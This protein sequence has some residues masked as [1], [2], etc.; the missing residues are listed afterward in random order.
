MGL[1]HSWQV[2]EEN[3]SKNNVLIQ[4]I[5][6]FSIA[7]L[8][9]A[10]QPSQPS[11]PAS[12]S[13]ASEKGIPA[14]SPD[15][16][17]IPTI[18]RSTATLSDLATQRATDRL[19]TQELPAPTP[20]P[21]PSPTPPLWPALDPQDFIT[22]QEMA[23][24]QNDELHNLILFSSQVT[25]PF[26]DRLIPY[27]KG[28]S[29]EEQAVSLPRLWAV[30]PDGKRAGVLT[31]WNQAFGAYLPPADNPK[32]KL[33][34]TRDQVFFNHERIQSIDLPQEC[35][36]ILLEAESQMGKELP[37]SNFKFSP[38]GRY[39]AFHF[40]PEM[41]YRGIIL[42]DVRSGRILLRTSAGV[43]HHYD[44]FPDGSLLYS[45]G[46]CEGGET[47]LF[48]PKTGFDIDLGPEG[49][50]AWNQTRTSIIVNETD[51]PGFPASIWGFNLDRRRLFVKEQEGLHVYDTHPIW[52][53]DDSHVLY[54]HQAYALAGSPLPSEYVFEQPAQI[55]RINASTG[56]KKTLVSERK[57][58]YHLCLFAHIPCEWRGDWLPVRRYPF[59]PTRTMASS[60]NFS[61][62]PAVKCVL[63]G[64]QCQ[65]SE[66]LFALNWRTGELLPWDQA[67]L[68]QPTSTST[69]APEDV[70]YLPPDPARTPVY[71]DP[72]GRYTLA[73]GLD[74]H[75]LWMVP[76]DGEPVVWVWYAE[77]FIY[78]P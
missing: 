44:F 26:Q 22:V 49:S 33:L 67:P 75:S 47:S 10:C 19:A 13:P 34:F 35:S 27:P 41:C 21:A 71:V 58:S 5:L 11:V 51:Y 73:V 3:M 54:Q 8:L 28:T 68:P 20:T 25:Q 38:D 64:S 77:W 39:L 16:T 4:A 36:G 45:T 42:L 72:Q 9:A 32:A 1:T 61:E 78:L 53:P 70:F 76:Q 66:E 15:P 56:E 62:I 43:G 23:N 74:G 59:E 24:P 63:E 12:R 14:N 69:P 40:G 48:D 6:I 18:L 29:P 57:Y 60:A 55:I 7:L 50:E 52:T 65:A 31:P 17:Q 46:H 2:L 30:S 37:Y